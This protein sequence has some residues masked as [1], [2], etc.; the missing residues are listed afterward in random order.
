MEEEKCVHEKLIKH[1]DV[2][3]NSYYILRK[4]R[5]SN[6]ETY[7]RIRMWLFNNNSSG[8]VVYLSLK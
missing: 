4:M 6:N 1:T 2:N 3:D 5:K 8:D 7:R